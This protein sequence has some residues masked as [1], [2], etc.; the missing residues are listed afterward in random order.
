MALHYIVS[1]LSTSSE[2]ADPVE[3]FLVGLQKHHPAIFWEMWPD[4][5]SQTLF[6]FLV[7]LTDATLHN[8]HEL[9]A[10]SVC[11]FCIFNQE[12]L[13]LKKKK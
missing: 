3:D 8:L 4:A 12:L 2:G 11:T 7:K 1:P 9:K 10:C 6:A 5:F 13:E